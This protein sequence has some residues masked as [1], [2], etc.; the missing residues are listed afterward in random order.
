[1][2]KNPTQLGE[3]VQ[4]YRHLLIFERIDVKWKIKHLQTWSLD[5]TERGGWRIWNTM[6]EVIATSQPQSA[7]LIQDVSTA[8]NHNNMDATRRKIAY[9]EKVLSKVDY[10]QLE[11]IKQW[12]Q[13]FGSK[14]SFTLLLA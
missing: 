7:S 6:R 4:W 11:N 5:N 8:K 3:Y 13:T 2:F 9:A 10:F 1:M 12:L 14:A